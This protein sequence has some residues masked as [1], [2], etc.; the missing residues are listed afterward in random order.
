MPGQ[1][2]MMSERSL[3]RYRRVPLA[4]PIC[5]AR[6]PRRAPASQ[7]ASRFVTVSSET[8]EPAIVVGAI[9][10]LQDISA[11]GELAAAHA[12]LPPERC[13]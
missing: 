3:Q 11:L 4:F 7:A 1:H 12:Q 13:S 8:V 10:L 6:W 2:A 5:E 9:M